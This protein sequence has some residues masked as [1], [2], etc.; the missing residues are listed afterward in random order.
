L[1]RGMVTTDDLHNDK[2]GFTDGP[3][4]TFDELFNKELTLDRVHTFHVE[5]SGK[6]LIP[7]ESKIF[8]F[9]RAGLY[10]QGREQD[11]A[12]FLKRYRYISHPWMTKA[13]RHVIHL[14]LKYVDE[15]TELAEKLPVDISMIRDYEKAFFEG[16]RTGREE[17]ENIL[18]GKLKMNVINKCRLLGWYSKNGSII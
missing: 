15:N 14:F 4:K 11:E 8:S 1:V 2:L 10:P 12:Y 9:P 18:S 13:E 6:S 3:V 17:I 7:E 16:Q 5:L